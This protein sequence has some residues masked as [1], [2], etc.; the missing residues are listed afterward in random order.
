[1]RSDGDTGSPGKE[2][3]MS[4]KKYY[5]GLLRHSE[6]TAP[7]LDEAQRDY[8]QAMAATSWAHILA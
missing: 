6:N 1:V 7:R 5:S 3:Q 8:D 2:N 4:F